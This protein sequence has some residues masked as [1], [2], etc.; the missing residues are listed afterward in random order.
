MPADLLRGALAGRRVLV[1]GHTGFAGTWAVRLL[2]A[3]GAEVA[4]YSRGSREEGAAATAL[5]VAFHADITDQS[6]VA[7]AM[8]SFAPEVVLH[9]AGN[10]VVAAAFRMP[11]ATF[12]A[13]ALGTVTV[14]D[15]ALRQQSVRSVVVAGTPAATSLP[16]HIGL[17]PYPASKI[18]AEA[19]VAAYAHPRTQQAAERAAPL[20]VGMARPG[21]ML[22]GDWAEGRLL[23][24]VVRAVNRGQPVTLHAPAAVRPWQHVLDAISG[25]LMLAVRLTEGALPSYR[26]DFGC[27]EP[28]E[29]VRD[30]V[31]GFLAA[32]GVPDWPVHSDGDGAEDRLELGYAAAAAEL[33]WRP[34]WTLADALSASAH[35]YRAVGRE[36]AALADVMDELIVS[37][38]SAAGLAWTLAAR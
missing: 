24:D 25:M 15:A 2:A 5:A 1:T 10:T 4:G 35:W 6:R 30:V 37:Y 22:G 27:L 38:T 18:A 16:G 13:N 12:S 19:A 9:L 7:S 23:A 29:R 14:L 21:V 8:A 17:G 20:G 36:P 3:L 28:G 34:A 31:G 11:A 26:Y 33:G 32:Y